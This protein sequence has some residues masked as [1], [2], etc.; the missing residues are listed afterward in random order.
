MAKGDREIPPPRLFAD[1]IAT[2][3]AAKVK[4]LI[5]MD[6]IHQRKVSEGVISHGTYSFRVSSS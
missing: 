1:G 6:D 4:L 5:N 2:N 3:D